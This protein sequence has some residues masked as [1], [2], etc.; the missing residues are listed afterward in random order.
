MMKKRLSTVRGAYVGG[1]AIL[2][3][4]AG[5]ACVTSYAAPAH[6]AAYLGSRL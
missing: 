1:G 5:L 6:A 4:Y 2:G 3:A